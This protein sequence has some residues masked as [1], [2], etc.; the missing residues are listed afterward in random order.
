[1]G[2]S[3]SGGSI[4]VQN[5]DNILKNGRDSRRLYNKT[6][7]LA[8]RAPVFCKTSEHKN[9]SGKVIKKTYRTTRLI[10]SHAYNIAA[11]GAGLYASKVLAH[12]CDALRLAAVKE[13]KTRRGARR[14]RAARRW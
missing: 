12:D 9:S 13:S 6:W 11:S 3:G 7:N 1:M 4:I 5:V 14:S 10:N 8:A 2:K